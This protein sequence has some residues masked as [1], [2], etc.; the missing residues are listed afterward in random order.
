[1]TSSCGRHS[2]NG[3]NAT[4]DR[5]ED[6][7]G[8]TRPDETHRAPCLSSGRRSEPSQLP[9]PMRQC[10]RLGTSVLPRSKLHPARARPQL[11]QRHGTHPPLSRQPRGSARHQARAAFRPIR[12]SPPS[13]ARS[14]YERPALYQDCL[15][16]MRLRGG[17][18]RRPGGLRAG[19][20]ERREAVLHGWLWSCQLSAER[21]ASFPDGR[22]LGRF[23]HKFV[24][25]P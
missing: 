18:L 4:G 9:F 20:A 10:Q 25:L 17:D 21:G 16:P 2:L 14:S 19:L 5:G 12:P 8:P 22:S 3:P 13:I 15:L 7:P 11:M 24:A 1:M 23:R 6:D